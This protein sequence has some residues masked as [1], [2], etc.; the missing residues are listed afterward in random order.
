MQPPGHEVKRVLNAL[1]QR[2]RVDFHE[3]N[4]MFRKYK[5]K[6]YQ[7]VITDPVT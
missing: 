5:P 7:I 4:F 2:Y 6:G 3:G 1:S